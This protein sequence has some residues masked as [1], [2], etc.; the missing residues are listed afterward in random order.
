MAEVKQPAPNPLAQIE[1]RLAAIESKHAAEVAVLEAK[2]A[3]AERKAESERTRQQG[4][5]SVED[6][7]YR[8]SLELPLEVRAQKTADERFQGTRRY[9]CCL[10][11]IEIDKPSVVLKDC[12]VIEI[13]ANSPEE[14]Q[15]RYQQLNGILHTERTIRAEE[16]RQAA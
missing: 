4:E 8:K 12:P 7:A 11:K 9:K 10:M 1:A 15:A 16:V 13:S 6:I 2:L 5:L 3:A 14:A